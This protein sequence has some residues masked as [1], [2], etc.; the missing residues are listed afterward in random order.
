MAEHLLVETQGPWNGPGCARLVEDAVT[1]AGAGDRVC[2]FLV[3]DGVAAAVPGAL[4]ALAELRRRGGTLWVDE[5]SLRR[6]AL[7]PAATEG[8]AVAM[9]AVAAKL[10]APDVRVV[11][12]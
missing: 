2:L 4:P 7:D 10:L 8:E 11:W 12:H 3:E 9:D 1:L 6:R 5:F